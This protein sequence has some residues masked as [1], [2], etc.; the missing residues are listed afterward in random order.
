MWL[1]V[2][3]AAL[4]PVLYFQGSG[5]LFAERYLVYPERG[6]CD[7]AVGTDH[8]AWRRGPVSRFSS[9][10]WRFFLQ[11][12]SAEIV[13]GRMRTRSIDGLWTSSHGR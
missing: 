2:S 8:A 13:I 9:S 3:A 1:G 7:F 6:H 11:L 12:H 5:I 10:S 4:L